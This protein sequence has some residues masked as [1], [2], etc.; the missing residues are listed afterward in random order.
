MPKV[1]FKPTAPVFELEKAVHAL[2]CAAIVIG[3]VYLLLNN[4]VGIEVL[5]EVVMMSCLLGQNVV[6]S[7]ESPQTFRRKKLPPFQG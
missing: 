7:V 4:I 3:I 5:T 6:Q 2:D 1:G